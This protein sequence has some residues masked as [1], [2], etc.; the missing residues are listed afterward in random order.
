MLFPTTETHVQDEVDED[1]VQD[2]LDG[3]LSP[4]T[5]FSGKKL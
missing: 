3:P 5:S 4:E 2:M 1:I